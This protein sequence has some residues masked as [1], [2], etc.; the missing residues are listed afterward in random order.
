[1]KSIQLNGSDFTNER[2]MTE[3]ISEMIGDA[4]IDKGITATSFAWCIDVDY[5]EEE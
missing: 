2:P 5:E 1:M 3:A 4:L